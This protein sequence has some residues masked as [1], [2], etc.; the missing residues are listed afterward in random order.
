MRHIERLAKPNILIEK[1][2][3]WLQKFIESDKKRPPN[4]Q[5]A[6]YEIKAT[7]EAMSHNKCFY[8]EQRLLG[9]TPQIDHFIEV[10]EDKMLAFEWLNLYLSCDN[11]NHKLANRILSIENVLNPCFHSDEEIQQHLSFEDEMIISKNNSQIGLDTIRKYKL[12]SERLNYLRSKVLI[13]FHQI[14][15]KILLA[16][17]N[18]NRGLNEREINILNQFKQPDRPFSLMFKILLEKYI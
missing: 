4:S 11:C 7:L 9:L 2:E 3:K 5:Y 12:D 10:A 17:E 18:E 1:E 6:H 15:T 13:Q 8:C 16:K 14:F